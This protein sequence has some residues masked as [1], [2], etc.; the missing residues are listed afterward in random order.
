MGLQSL[1]F[2]RNLLT[3]KI[4]E[5]IGNMELLES[6]DLLMNRLYVEI[7]SSFSNLNFLNH[8][9]LSYNLTGKI[10]SGIQLPKL[11]GPPVTKIC[12]VNSETPNVTN[13]GSS[14]GSN[15][16]WLLCAY[17]AWICDGVL[18]SSGSPVFHQVL[19]VCL[20]STMAFQV[21]YKVH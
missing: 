18:G 10:P 21:L 14:E 8:L 19:E 6:L 20:L 13:G 7:P 5:N 15:E 4:P 12:S 3:G 16:N 11:C 1:N 2:S 17:S 9:N